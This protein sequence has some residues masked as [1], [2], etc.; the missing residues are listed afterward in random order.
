MRISKYKDLF[1]KYSNSEHK[2]N[3]HNL[4]IM[5]VLH[6][7]TE[8]LEISISWCTRERYHV[9]DIRHTCYKQ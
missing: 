5:R 1:W 6:K 4:K 3:S 9:T 8:I 7:Y 2:K